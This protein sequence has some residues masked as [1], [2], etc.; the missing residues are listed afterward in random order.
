M[1]EEI[2]ALWDPIAEKDDWSAFEQKL[3]DTQTMAQAYGFG[4]IVADEGQK[5]L[6]AAQGQAEATGAAAQP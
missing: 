5:A 3:A 2:E 4:P 1:I 6:A